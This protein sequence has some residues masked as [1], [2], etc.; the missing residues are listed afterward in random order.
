MFSTA[1]AHMMPRVR[2]KQG[3]WKTNH[4]SITKFLVARSRRTIM[5]GNSLTGIAI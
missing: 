4:L 3:K 1:S 5:P 2:Q